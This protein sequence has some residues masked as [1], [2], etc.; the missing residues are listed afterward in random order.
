VLD[1]GGRIELDSGTLGL[2]VNITLPLAPARPLA[3][4]PRLPIG[5]A[6]AAEILPALTEDREARRLKYETRIR[7]GR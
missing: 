3:V 2:C 1:H 7:L 6:P 5:Q 4:A